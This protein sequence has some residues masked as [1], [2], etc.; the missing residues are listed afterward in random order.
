MADLRVAKQDI[1]LAE[2]VQTLADLRTLDLRGYKH[3]TLERRMRKRMQRLSLSSYSQYLSVF[4]KN[5]GEAAELLNT[6]LINVTEFF[7]DPAAWEALRTSVLPALLEGLK[8]GGVFRA[9]CPACASGEEPYSL[10]ILLAEYFGRRLPQQDIKIYATDID[11]EALSTARRGEY[12]RERLHRLRP[13]WRD[14]YFSASG[15]SV[16]IVRGIRKMVIFGRSNV[17]TD[18]PISHC[19]LIVCR[20]LLIYFD[21]AS[22]REIMKRL[23]YALDRDGVLFLGK[24]ESKLSD[25]QAFQPINARWR[26]FRKIASDE[27]GSVR[28]ALVREV[29]TMHS[30]KNH[31]IER[32]LR[33]RRLRERLLLDTVHSGVILLD[34]AN[35]IVK[36]NDGATRIWNLD[37]EVDGQPILSTVI[38]EKCPELASRLEQAR[39]NSQEPV[40]FRASIRNQADGQDHIIA[41]NLR[42]MLDESHRPVGLVMSCEDVSHQDTL[43]HAVEKLESTGEQ[44]QSTN[45]EL[46][47]SNEELRSTNEE[48]ETANEELQSTNEELETTNEELQSTNEELETANEELQSLN[49]ELENMNEELEHRTKEM[50]KHSERYA[51]TLRTLPFPVMLLDKN[52]QVQLWNSAAQKLFGIASSSVVGLDFRQLPLADSLRKLFLRRCQVVLQRQESCVL[53]NQRVNERGRDSFDVHFAPVSHGSAGMEGVLVIFGPYREAGPGPKR[54]AGVGR[55]PGATTKKK[56]SSRARSSKKRR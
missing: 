47:T 9:W 24:A 49:E 25:S 6:V 28:A 18:A 52:E 27:N 5:P 26:I 41:I 36:H 50:N 33:N 42:V 13:E 43:R 53:R 23:H 1:T 21:I 20:N 8:P 38:A 51:E 56:T 37:G 19:S 3:G 16:R 15:S 32:E 40:A 4:L 22:Q 55:K 54:A 48:L 17:L 45:E 35:V 30:P 29:R 31:E 14:K 44:L 10:A 12:P 46:E 34:D 11:E 2:M 39:R 7:R